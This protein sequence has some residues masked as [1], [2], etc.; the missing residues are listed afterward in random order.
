MVNEN[1]I[2][3]EKYDEPTLLGSHRG[4][5][6]YFPR[7]LR[8]NKFIDIPEGFRLDAPVDM[9][10][11][12]VIPTMKFDSVGIS[13]LTGNRQ[14]I[15]TALIVKCG[16]QDV[17]FIQS[18]DNLREAYSCRVKLKNFFKEQYLNQEN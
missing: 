11:A 4:M 14:N 7:G 6:V 1:R 9:A 12:T 10:G 16:G 3:V 2:I 17:F 5:N 8:T 18:H 15:E 13:T